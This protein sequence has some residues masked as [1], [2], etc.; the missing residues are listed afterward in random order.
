MIALCREQ[1]GRLVKGKQPRRLSGFDRNIIDHHP[2]KAGQHGGGR[3]QDHAVELDPAILNHPLHLTPTGHAC[4]REEL[5][6]AFAGSG[7]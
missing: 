2:G 1:S 4:T 6:D 7:F 3:G 5:G